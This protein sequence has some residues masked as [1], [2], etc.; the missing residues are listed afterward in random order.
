ML[1]SLVVAIQSIN[2]QTTNPTVC[3]NLQSGFVNDPTS[4][5]AYYTCVNGLGYPQTCTEGFHFNPDIGAC[6]YPKPDGS[7]AG[8]I[9]CPPGGEYELFPIDGSC[10]N[11]QLCFL[12]KGSIES[13]AEG[14]QFDKTLK[15]CDLIERVQCVDTSDC[16]LADV[17]GAPVF[18]AHP[19]DCTKY[20]YCIKGAANP[21]PLQCPT[22]TKFDLAQRTCIIGNCTVPV[23]PVPHFQP[24]R[25]ADLFFI[26]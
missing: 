3:G 5:P 11:F 19:T 10:V 15:I 8:I 23:I 7:C 1:L 14:L 12:G 4:C 20:H 13:C 22:G 21:T 17:P 6:D 25:A 26:H 24:I 2:A 18:I 16:P 9:A